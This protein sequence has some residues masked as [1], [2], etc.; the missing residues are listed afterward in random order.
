[1]GAW[2]V[3]NVASGIVHRGISDA[4]GVVVGIACRPRSLP[5][6]A[7]ISPKERTVTCAKCLSLKR[8]PKRPEGWTG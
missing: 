3:E 2:T 5:A 4:A 1:M 8:S 7:R 6:A